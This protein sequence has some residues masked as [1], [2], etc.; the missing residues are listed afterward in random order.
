MLKSIIIDDDELSRKALNQA[1]SRCDN[2]ECIKEYSSAKEALYDVE[3]LDCD[4]IF[5]DIE[6]PEM[7]GLEFIEKAQNI[8]QIII[9]SAKTDY[10]AEAFNYD[11]TDYIVKPFDYERFLKSINKALS[12]NEEVLNNNAN[13]CHMFFKKNSTLVRVNFEDIYYIEAYADYVAIYSKDQKFVVLST[14]KA[15]EQRFSSK[16]FMRIHRSYI[17]RLD[18]IETIEDN[19]VCINGKAIPISRSYKPEFI[20]SMNIF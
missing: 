6:M 19:S 13:E 20:K 3:K 15:I 7:N 18:K 14:M 1:I 5:L 10:A 16:D 9:I 2:I 8:P 12:I 17:I 4:L 11:V